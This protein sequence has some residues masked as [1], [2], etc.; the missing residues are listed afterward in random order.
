MN[1]FQSI[2]LRFFRKKLLREL[3]D[4]QRPHQIHTIWSARSMSILFDATPEADR[5]EVLD[6]AR[7]L[8]KDGR[9]VRLLAY[10]HDKKSPLE[11]VSFDS[12]NRKNTTWLGL[13][14]TEKADAFAREKTDLL[15]LFDGAGRLPL[16]WIAARSQA[17]MK[18]GPL[19]ENPND[20]DIM[21]ETPPGSDA[22][23]FLKQ[24][25]IYLDKILLPDAT[26]PSSNF[27]RQ[28]PIAR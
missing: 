23:F 28:S 12:F 22:R 20:F 21:L 19:T 17:C 13:P 9:K 4:L 1:F 16:E 3:A 10:W 27:K 6:F 2:R 14:K 7:S 5:R 26:A 18:I 15:L 25:D 11:P 8:E 24:L